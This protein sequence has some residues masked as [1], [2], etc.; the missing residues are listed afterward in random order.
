MNLQHA[1]CVK[2]ELLI[3]RPVAAAFNPFVD[4]A[5]T[6]KFWFN[7]SSGQL[8]SGKTIQWYWDISPEPA[9]V[10]V[11]AIE[12][13]RRI[14][15]EWGSPDEFTTVEWLFTSRP[16]NTTWVSITNTGFRGDGDA[17]VHQ[18]LDAMGGFTLVLAAAKV[19][20]EHNI[21]LNIVVDRFPD[22][23]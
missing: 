3:R 16:D 2:A 6:T 12:D 14:L 9:Q 5:V 19:L 10:R 15:I 17:V 7:R 22:A 18:A 23:R 1:P 11:K 13:N 4:P 20:L 21:N 8:Q